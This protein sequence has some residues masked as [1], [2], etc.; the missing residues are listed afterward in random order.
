[1]RRSPYL[2]LSRPPLHEAGL[3][4]ALVHPGGVWTRVRVVARTGSTNADLA[5]AARAGAA[6][7]DV[8]VAEA[9][10]AGRGR[11][12]RSWVAPAQASIIASVLL[13]PAGRVPPARLGWLPLMAGVALVGAVRRLAGVPV[14][15]KWPNDLLVRAGTAE[16][17][18]GWGKCAGVLA[19]VVG[20]GA[21]VVG[22]GL[23]V[24]QRADELPAPPY[25]GGY[26][27]T[28][29]ALCGARTTDRDPLLRA[30]LRDLADWYVLWTTE[31]GDPEASGLR[32][33]YT[34]ACHTLG[35]VVEVAL[36]G[37]ATRVGRASEI[38]LDGRL[39]LTDDDGEHALAAG[40]IVRVR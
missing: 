10:T 14:T 29:L 36:P 7:G 9:Q 11:L 4:R 20:D 1:M 28:S 6:S 26:P 27:P 34:E 23:N 17:D 37:L 24:S 3:N 39:V 2:D 5:E 21:V 12:D 16:G 18:A 35:R 22:F 32:T 38:D 25:P 30:V 19:E 13:R 40:D 31:G 33:A 8:L 15:L